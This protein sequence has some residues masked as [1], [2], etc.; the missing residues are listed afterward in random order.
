[1]LNAL[2]NVFMLNVIMLKFVMVNAIT[3]NVVVLSVAAPCLQ[4]MQKVNTIKGLNETKTAPIT[5][6]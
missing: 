2:M 5:A 1:M 3:L 6:S 4:L